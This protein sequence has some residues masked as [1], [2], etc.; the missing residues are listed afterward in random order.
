MAA[1]SVKDNEGIQ[2]PEPKRHVPSGLSCSFGGKRLSISMSL[3]VETSQA[4]TLEVLLSNVA[5]YWLENG[6]LD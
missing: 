3:R 4:N 2:T 1:F 5:G 6:V